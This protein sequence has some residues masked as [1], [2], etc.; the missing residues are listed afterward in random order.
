MLTKDEVKHIAA[1]AKLHLTEA[2]IEKYQHD[3]SGILDWIGI[4]SECETE[5]VEI[6]S[7]VTGLQN[8]WREGDLIENFGK[9]KDLLNCTPNQV[10]KNQVAIPNIMK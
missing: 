3:L 8:V 6:T 4:L 9:E 5:N 1:L 7:Q 10:V 2:E